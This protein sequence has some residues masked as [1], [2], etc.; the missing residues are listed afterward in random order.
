MSVTDQTSQKRIKNKHTEAVEQLRA[1]SPQMYTVPF[2]YKF[3]D[4]S[5]I[6]FFKKWLKDVPPI[7]PPM[8]A[9]TNG[10]YKDIKETLPY[11]QDSQETYRGAQK[12]KFA[13]KVHKPPLWI[14]VIYFELNGLDA[15]I[16]GSLESFRH[17]KVMVHW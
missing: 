11:R 10:I 9:G 7:P 2:S 6:D 1:Y 17:Q 13:E 14:N 3:T 5:G 4:A 16:D 8:T 12:A 15:S